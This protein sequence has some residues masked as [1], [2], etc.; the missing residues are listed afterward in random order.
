MQINNCANNNRNNFISILK[1]KKYMGEKRILPS[2][3]YL[4]NKVVFP[5]NTKHH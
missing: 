4:I 1:N 2:V 5:S 3:S